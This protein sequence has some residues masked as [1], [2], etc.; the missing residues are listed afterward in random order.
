MKEHDIHPDHPHLKAY[1]KDFH[2]QADESKDNENDKLAFGRLIRYFSRQFGWHYIAPFPVFTKTD[3]FHANGAFLDNF[4]LVQ[5]LWFD[6]SDA[7]DPDD[8]ISQL[9]SAGLP[10]RNTLFRIKSRLLL[11][12]KGRRS[13]EVEFVEPGQ[14]ASLLKIFLKSSLK[15]YEELNDLSEILSTQGTVLVQTWIDAIH[16]EYEE[17]AK[18]HEGCNALKA[19][20]QN[21]ML[22]QLHT[23]LFEEEIVKYLLIRNLS[24]KI[25]KRSTYITASPVSR[26]IERVFAKSSALRSLP[27][28]LI[29]AEPVIRQISA[30]L[31][32]TDESL[33]FLEGILAKL[34]PLKSHKKAAGY[35]QNVQEKIF[36]R[37]LADS[38]SFLLSAEFNQS[39]SDSGVHVLNPF[40]GKGFYLCE[41]LQKLD[42]DR[43][44]DKY[45]DDL[46]GN[47]AQILPYFLSL[48]NIEN[49][50]LSLTGEYAPFKGMSIV[51]SLL[52][53]GDRELVLYN[54]E[55][56]QRVDAQSK[57][58][59]TVLLGELPGL[60]TNH[61]GQKGSHY[62]GIEKRVQMTYGRASKASNK[63]VISDDYVKAIR[64]ATDRLG[65]R[66]KGLIALVCKNNFVDDLAFDGMRKYLEK[67]FDA[68]YVIDVYKKENNNYFIGDKAVLIL[69]KNDRIHRPGIFYHRG[70]WDNFLQTVLKKEVNLYKQFPW[71]SIKPDKQSTWLTEGLRKDF[72]ALMPIGTKI[73]K[74]GKGNAI[75]HI[76]GRGV[77]TSRDAWIY[78]FNREHLSANV[79]EL[80]GIYNHHVHNWGQLPA[81]PT[82][83]EYLGDATGQIPWSDGLKNYLLRQLPI[84]YRSASIREAHYRPFVK[85]Y[86]YFDQ[87]LVERWY[88][89]P[90]MLPSTEAE[91]ENRIICVSSPG[92]KTI[93]S[94]MTNLIPDLNL[95]AGASPVQCFPL[96]S[97][98]RDGFSRRENISDWALESFITHFKD[99]RIS[100]YDIFHYIYAVLHHPQYIRKYAA[101]LKKQLP[102]IPF[103]SPFDVL[104]KAGK[105]L[106]RLHL[107]YEGQEEYPLKLTYSSTGHPDWIFDK[108]GLEENHRRIRINEELSVSKIPAK[109]Y[110]YLLGNRPALEWVVDQ[111]RVREGQVTKSTDDPNQSADPTFIT[112]LIGQVVTV[113][114][115]TIKIINDLP[116]LD[117]S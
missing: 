30:Q 52:L 10:L 3:V 76:Y 22:P 92:S 44:S 28:I 103:V 100:K 31:S 74:A 89:M 90:N 12:R 79:Q 24:D 37:F 99:F 102:R 110:T 41:L 48:V 111:Y 9:I 17:N 86:L 26:E 94:F 70:S 46:F 23:A 107:F 13:M 8:Q 5:G 57:I 29:E 116:T 77:S 15:R 117:S 50:Y 112:R 93:S 58:D 109:A 27:G 72:D 21:Y 55:N 6:L 18:F 54:D 64:W 62:S 25:F 14:G 61:S 4:N 104:A 114:L 43:I 67:E 34:F 84:R 101:N 60:D 75:F 91:K 45:S 33:I 35:Y 106:A 51:D 2:L 113:S 39:L 95:F 20:F 59:M 115:E 19:M 97:Y 63:S 1:L 53:S 47:E 16:R 83:E 66:Q 7:E 88:Q 85:K 108:M 36:A 40:A 65:T 78:N 71:R 87:H 73:S 32:G 68:V 96:Y 69:V 38:V 105:D 56:S 49:Q 98:D 81:K 80:I 42:P 82:I 11:W